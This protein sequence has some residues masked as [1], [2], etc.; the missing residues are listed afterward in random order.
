MVRSA[1]FRRKVGRDLA[2]GYAWYEGQDKGLGEQFLSA[3]NAAF[4]AIE[5]YPEMFARVH[6]EVR[7]T[8]VSRFPYAVFYRVEPK[9]VV[10]LTVLH[11]A[12]DPKLWPQSLRTAR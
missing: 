8:V 7:R 1:V 12:R 4:D 10:V 5:R 6:G 3:V 11:T 2:G 9:R